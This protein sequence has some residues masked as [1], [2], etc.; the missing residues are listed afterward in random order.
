MASDDGIE[1]DSV[2]ESESGESIDD[3]E[4][5]NFSEDWDEE[6]NEDDDDDENYDYDFDDGCANDDLYFGRK[7]HL[8]HGGYHSDSILD[9]QD[10]ADTMMLLERVEPW[11]LVTGVNIC[12]SD[13]IHR[14]GP[15]IG[16]NQWLNI[17]EVNCVKASFATAVLNC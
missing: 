12:C 15:A 13:W 16:D 17:I 1:S 3:V 8:S 2:D 14:S 6:F 5:E 7:F 4:S 9:L 10:D 11:V